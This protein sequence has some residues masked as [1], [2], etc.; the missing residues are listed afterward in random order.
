VTA[1]GRPAIADGATTWT[2]DE[3]DARVR[4]WATTVRA[5]SDAGAH[6]A[7]DLP[8]GAEAIAAWLGVL[9]AGRAVVALDPT[10]PLATRVAQLAFA[11]VRMLI[12]APADARALRDA[13]WSGTVLAAPAP[14]DVALP[15]VDPDAS[16]CLHYTSGSSGAPKAV[17]WTHR[18]LARAAANIGA[19]LALASD[20]RHALLAPLAVAAAAAQVV[21]CRTAGACLCLHEARRSPPATTAAWLRA[22]EITTLQTVPSLF[23]T[24]AME[25]SSWRT[26][27]AVKLGGEA[28]TAAD[29]RRFAACAAP[30][31]VL[32]NGLGLTEAGFNV[33]WQ[34]WR[35]GDPLDGIA[36]PIGRAAPDVELVLDGEE[37]VVRSPD[38]ARGYWR[39]DART[40]SRY[41]D[42]PGRPGW[43]ELRTGDA[44]RLR[45]DGTYEHAGRLD[46]VV[47]VHG[48]RVDPADV[49]AALLALDR[50]RDA[51]VVAD[52]SRLAA[53]VVGEGLTGA[54]VRRA[55]AAS[56]PAPMVPATIRVVDALPR[57]TTGKVDR[58]MLAPDTPA[59]VR[60]PRDALERTLHASFRRVLPEQGFG[61]DAS[62]F[63]LGGDSLAA[64]ELFAALS[65]VLHVELPLAEL[66]RFPTV[67][68]LAARIRDGGWNLTDEPVALLSPA[69]DRDAVALFVWPG[70]GSDVMALADLARH[71]GSG[72]A[73]HAIQ[74]RGADGRRV[75]DTRLDDMADR[76]VALVRRVQPRGPYAL[77]GTSF[78]GL[79]ALEVARRLRA[80][81]EDVPVLALLDTYAPGY[82]A[83]RRDLGL[84]D[85]VRLVRRALR[86]LGHKDE[87]GWPALRRGLRE[88]ALRLRARVALRRPRPDAPPLP[89]TTRF[90]YLQEACFR[91]SIS[92]RLAPYEGDVDL[93]R[94]DTPPPA[95][96][97][98]LDDA[99]GWR[100]FVTGALRVDVVPGRHSWHLREP[101]V[102]VLADKL[103]ACLAR[104]TAA[105]AAWDAKRIW[106]ALAPWGDGHAGDAGSAAF[107][108]AALAELERLIDV[109]PGERVL[110]VA[111]G[112][113]WLSRRL[114]ERGGVV[115]GVDVSDGMLRHA[116]ARA[117]D[118]GIDFRRMDAT[119]AADWER[120]DRAAYDVAVCNLALHDLADVG[121]LFRSLPGALRPSGRLVLGLVHPAPLL[122]GGVRPHVPAARLATPDQPRPHVEVTRPLADVWS[123]AAEAGWRVDEVVEVPPGAPAFA[124]A[125]L[126]R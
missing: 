29:A 23:R 28:V 55:L 80:L 116:R 72:V 59:E 101:N 100:P 63:D 83:V 112:T 78:G 92:A 42:V 54:A 125:V 17:V 25:P 71:L 70:A 30:D 26:V 20:D 34:V 102:Q 82:P 38:L 77:C 18:T 68:T 2:H 96:L 8:H 14:A 98:A 3:L 15:D 114:A 1:G 56:L 57:L 36:V 94:V 93:F 58:R 90:V 44:G 53:F 66:T 45:S 4:A 121:P 86:P 41:R 35:A 110:D 65:A 60:G 22:Q 84:S 12:A 49:E 73:L 13:G 67:E 87:P 33:C 103:R 24:L 97:F 105:P 27:R 64:A 9:A 122:R 21:A 69:P 113:G 120:L 6:V 79:V 7:I 108:A 40:A 111:C 88:Q 46:R 106:D 99:L 74:H 126:R 119:R 115:T 91:A 19:M 48:H 107:G 62:F 37:I 11:D 118:R 10:H 117:G 81:G 85:R 123:A 16:S 51:A 95:A 39:D 76:G 124:L 43:R 5:E 61:I 32:I 31:A 52:G 104:T 50:V 89:L 47:K 75:W 109:R